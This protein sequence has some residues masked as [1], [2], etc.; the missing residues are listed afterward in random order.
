MMI[1]LFGLKHCSTC[2][3]AKKWLEAHDIDY[4]FVDVRQEPP[5]GEQLNRWAAVVGWDKLINKASQTWRNLA[6]EDKN[7]E[8]ASKNVDLVQASP[9]V[10]KRPLLVKGDEVLLGFA[11][12]KYQDLFAKPN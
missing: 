9:S 6:E 5:S 12:E 3:K 11:E 1:E 10:M 2:V 8:N 4:Q 7:I